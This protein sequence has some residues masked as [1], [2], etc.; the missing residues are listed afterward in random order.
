MPYDNPERMNSITAD[1]RY[2]HSKLSS[3][4]KEASPLPAFTDL[5]EMHNEFWQLIVEMKALATGMEA[6]MA[7]V[8]EMRLAVCAELPQ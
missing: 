1:C 2:L 8:R 6:K 5:H 4:S 7:R 3:L